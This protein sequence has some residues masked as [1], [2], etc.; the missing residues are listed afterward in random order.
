M[1]RSLAM[2]KGLP[3]LGVFRFE[4]DVMG[5]G[6]AV[7]IPAALKAAGL[8]LNA[9]DLFEINEAFG[10]QFVY[11][12]NKLGLDPAKVN[13]NGGVM[14]IGHPLGA[15]VYMI[16]IVGARCVVTLLHEMKRRGKDSRFGVIFMC[17]DH[18]V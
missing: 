7:A 16:F 8:E 13:G 1:K 18:M 3:I 10:S 12:R 6:P 17:I 5:V 9:I 11:C 14:A 2:Q 4:P 15:T